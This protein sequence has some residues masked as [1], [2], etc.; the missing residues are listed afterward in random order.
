M[1]FV[2]CSFKSLLCRPVLHFF[3]VLVPHLQNRDNS[4]A[5]LHKVIAEITMLR[6]Y[7]N[8]S[9]VILKIARDAKGGELACVKHGLWLGK[10]GANLPSSVLSQSNCVQVPHAAEVSDEFILGRKKVD[11]YLPFVEQSQSMWILRSITSSHL[12][13]PLSLTSL[14]RVLHLAHV[15][16]LPLK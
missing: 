2:T 11:I 10:D 3:C 14:S 13:M 4:M 8:Q 5:P 15:Y 9:C 7:G 6:C 12:P 1:C 16:A